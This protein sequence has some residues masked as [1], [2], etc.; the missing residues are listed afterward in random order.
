MA[1][2]PNAATGAQA[3]QREAPQIANASSFIYFLSLDVPQKFYLLLSASDFRA[4]VA[5]VTIH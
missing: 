4:V 1:A 3:D 5:A 2:R